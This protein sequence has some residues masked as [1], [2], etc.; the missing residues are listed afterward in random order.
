MDLHFRDISNY[1]NLT[2]KIEE[3]NKQNIP[4]YLE[5]GFGSGIVLRDRAIKEPNVFHLGFEAQN[6]YIIR[7]EEFLKKHKIENVNL[8]NCDAKYIIPRF[9]PFES[10]E[11]IMIYY[12]DPWWKKKHKKYILFDLTFIG[13]LFR[14]LKKG[15]TINIKTDVDEYFEK[16]KELF[17][18]FDYFEETP[19]N[20]KSC[21]TNKSTFEL[22]AIKEGRN[23][24]K[25][26]YIKKGCCL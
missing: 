3:M 24:N 16:I 17:N 10:I 7:T 23:L 5:I 6:I 21:E 13:D 20:D 11:K 8:L 9:I 1:C 2:N 26:A 22:N 25:I 19:F 12:P 15:G 14:V 18:L 4:V